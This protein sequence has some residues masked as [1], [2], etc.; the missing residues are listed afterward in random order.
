MDLGSLGSLDVGQL[1]QYL[2]GAY[3]G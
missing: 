1:R 3:R 2:I